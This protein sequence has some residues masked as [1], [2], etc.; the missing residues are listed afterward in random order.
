MLTTMR[1]ANDLD[2]DETIAQLALQLATVALKSS[3]NPEGWSSTLT[4]DAQRPALSLD[5]VGR[6]TT[7]RDGPEGRLR[8]VDP[9]DQGV[10][11]RTNRL[12]TSASDHGRSVGHGPV[13]AGTTG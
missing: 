12:L 11:D 8:P 13:G 9:L 10:V 5:P 7:A 4:T 2:N 6:P 1:R 3:P